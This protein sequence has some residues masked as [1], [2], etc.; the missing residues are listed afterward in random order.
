MW[1]DISKLYMFINIRFISTFLKIHKIYVLCIN[2]Y[3]YL[4]VW[5][6]INMCNTT[7][8]SIV[9]KIFHERSIFYASDRLLILRCHEESIPSQLRVISNSMEP[10]RELTSVGFESSSHKTS[11][12]VQARNF[13]HIDVLNRGNSRTFNCAIQNCRKFHNTFKFIEIKLLGSVLILV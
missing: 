10:C 4:F 11:L 12:F 13:G 1:I 8:I 3:P 7:L 6:N 5:Q 9:V 2:G